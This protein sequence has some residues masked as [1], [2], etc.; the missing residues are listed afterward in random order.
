MKGEYPHSWCQK[1]CEWFSSLGDDMIKLPP[2]RPFFLLSALHGECPLN[3]EDIT[4]PEEKHPEDPA[5]LS[6][7]LGAERT[8]QLRMEGPH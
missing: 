6:P 1:C 3:P 7:L 2:K 8:L 4:F 5:L